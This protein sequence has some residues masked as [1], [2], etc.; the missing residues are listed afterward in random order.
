L[1]SFNQALKDKAGENE[2]KGKF[3]KEEASPEKK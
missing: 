1:D 3:K 2:D